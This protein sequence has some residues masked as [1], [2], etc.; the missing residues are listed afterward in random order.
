[1]LPASYDEECRQVVAVCGSQRILEGGEG[2]PELGGIAR[3]DDDRDVRAGEEPREGERRGIAPPPELLEGIEHGVGAEVLVRAAAQRHPR[4][5]RRRLVASVLSGK[6]AAAQRAERLEP[7]TVLG[8][9]GEYV[10]L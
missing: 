10:R 3:A 7:D 9:E 1:P 4:S 6:P 2:G 5:L 8:A